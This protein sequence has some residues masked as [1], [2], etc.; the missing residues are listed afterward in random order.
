MAFSRE[1]TVAFR[2]QYETHYRWAGEEPPAGAKQFAD[3]QSCYEYLRS[4]S[5]VTQC[6]ERLGFYPLPYIPI[7]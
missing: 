2:S 6:V 3:V 4:V 5:G 1:R 7:G